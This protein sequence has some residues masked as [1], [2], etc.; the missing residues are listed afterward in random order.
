M[1]FQDFIRGGLDCIEE[2]GFQRDLNFA[3]R[4]QCNFKII[5][6]RT[7]TAF[8][9]FNRILMRYQDFN[10]N[11]ITFQKFSETS[12]MFQDFIKKSMNYS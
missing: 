9:D 6:R 5:M 12:M 10:D 11:L 1:K 2:M 7:A 3:K 8:H 4:L